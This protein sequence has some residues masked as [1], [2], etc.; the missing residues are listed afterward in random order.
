MVNYPELIIVQVSKQKVY[1]LGLKLN[2]KLGDCLL[3][4]PKENY[5]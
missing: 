4:K 2:I 5:I 1:I 3:S